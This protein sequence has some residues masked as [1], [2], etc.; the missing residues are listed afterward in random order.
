VQKLIFRLSLIISAVGLIVALGEVYRK[1]NHQNKVLA[2]M[3]IVIND[4]KNAPK[5]TPVYD[6]DGVPVQSEAEVKALT[7]ALKMDCM[8]KV[9]NSDWKIPTLCEPLITS[10]LADPFDRKDLSF[11]PKRHVVLAGILMAL[12]PFYFLIFRGAVRRLP[13]RKPKE[14][15]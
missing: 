12:A 4:V 5:T 13:R 3:A 11:R 6:A 10:I 7:D 2:E 14:K 1:S 15:N 8:T 9:V